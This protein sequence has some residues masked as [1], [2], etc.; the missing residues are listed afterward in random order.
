MNDLYIGISILIVSMVMFIYSSLN[1][2]EYIKTPSMKLEEIKL[3]F[4]NICAIKYNSQMYL[5]S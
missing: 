3:D 1:K 5:I 2:E 4:D